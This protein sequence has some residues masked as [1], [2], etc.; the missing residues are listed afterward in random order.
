[1]DSRRGHVIA[2]V[3][4]KVTHMQVLYDAR[5]N[6][7]SASGV[8]ARATSCSNIERSTTKLQTSRRSRGENGLNR[9]ELLQF[10]FSKPTPE[11]TKVIKSARKDMCTEKTP[12]ECNEENSSLTQGERTG[13]VL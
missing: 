11:S 1:M 8:V 10:D 2:T 12:H 3:W 7:G 9:F 6:C 4:V 5:S 13:E